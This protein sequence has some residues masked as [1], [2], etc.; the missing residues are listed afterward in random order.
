MLPW[1]WP[2]PNWVISLNQLWSMAVLLLLSFFG[3]KAVIGRQRYKTFLT[4][5]DSSMQGNNSKTDITDTTD[6]A[7]KLDNLDNKDNKW[8]LS[9]TNSQNLGICSDQVS[10][11]SIFF[12]TSTIR[13]KY[14]FSRPKNTRAVHLFNTCV[15]RSPSRGSDEIPIDCNEARASG[16]QLDHLGYSSTQF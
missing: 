14:K 11:G 10:F 15:G 6:K 13:T 9:N 1:R 16:G 4:G 8:Y 3:V 5:Q 7:D 12:P 2:W